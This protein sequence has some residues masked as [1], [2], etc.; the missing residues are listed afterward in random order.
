[1]SRQ[2]VIPPLTQAAEIVRR[3]RQVLLLVEFH[4]ITVEQR[5]YMA[6]TRVMELF[7]GVP[8]YICIANLSAKDVSLPKY[9]IVVL[10]ANDLFNAL[11]T[12]KGQTD[13]LR[14]L[15][16]TTAN[17]LMGVGGKSVSSSIRRDE[18]ISAEPESIQQRKHNRDANEL[19]RTEGRTDTEHEKRLKSWNKNFG[20]S[21]RVSR[22]DFNY[23]LRTS[24]H[25]GWTLA[26]IKS[27]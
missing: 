22:Q 13:T 24:V 10:V 20:G 17:R 3:Y 1:M 5:S 18:H 4:P 6:A 26:S 25:V 8:C 2:I 7:P 27:S 21:Q 14:E 16:C 23:F 9:M 19:S 15:C 11:Y 12:W